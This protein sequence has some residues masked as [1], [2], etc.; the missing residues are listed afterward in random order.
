MEIDMARDGDDLESVA[1]EMLSSVC[2][3]MDYLVLHFS[4]PELMIY[5]PVV[6]EQEGRQIRHPEDPGSR[7][8]LCSFIGKRISTVNVAADAITIQLGSGDGQISFP[9]EAQERLAA[10]YIPADRAGRLRLGDALEY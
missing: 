3:V 4:G 2:F 9:L 10:E 8:A 7:D 6:V 1:R 5:A